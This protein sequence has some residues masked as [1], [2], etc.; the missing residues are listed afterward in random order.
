[1]DNDNEK[2]VE[3]EIESTSSISKRPRGTGSKKKG[4]PAPK[5]S[6]IKT[7]F[8]DILGEFRKVIWPSKP[9]LIKQTAT[10]IITSLVIG[11]L[12]CGYDYIFGFG[13]SLLMRLIGA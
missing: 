5:P 13:Y 10:V 6:R 2:L 1:M 9:E 7:F 11:G 8:T 4:S 12:I 3:T